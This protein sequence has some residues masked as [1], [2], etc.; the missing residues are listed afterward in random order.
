MKYLV[1]RFIRFLTKKII[2]TR[3][4]K[5]CDKIKTIKSKNGNLN[6]CQKFPF[7]IERI[8]YLNNLK[9]ILLDHLTHIKN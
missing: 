7:K 9:K 4:E 1:I 2:L 5:K 3:N 8:Y 6:V